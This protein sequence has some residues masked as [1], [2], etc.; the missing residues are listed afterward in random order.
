MSGPGKSK[1]PAA[2]DSDP[3]CRM[4]FWP[5]T[6]VIISDSIRPWRQA[7]ASGVVGTSESG[8]ENARELVIDDPGR[9][10]LGGRQ[11]ID[12]RI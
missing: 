11:E 1:T 3:L 10:N 7:P 8:A 2:A 9:L 6:D 12:G 4:Y 5:E